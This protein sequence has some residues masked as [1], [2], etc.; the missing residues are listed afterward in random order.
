M[1]AVV[2]LAFYGKPFNVKLN[3]AFIFWLNLLAYTK[4]YT[5]LISFFTEFC[6]LIFAFYYLM[7][8]V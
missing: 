7:Q 1:N 5:S 4:K 6:L 8:T 3:I 2:S